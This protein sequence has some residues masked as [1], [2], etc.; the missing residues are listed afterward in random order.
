[1]K[2]KEVIQLIE[3]FAPLNLQESYDNA[4]LN[5]G[6]SENDVSGVLCT[7]DIT[8]KVIEEAIEL[9][10]NLIISHHPII[11][12]GIKSL[13]GRSENERIVIQAIQ[14]DIALYAAHTN[15]DNATGGVNHKIA[16]KL[17][18]SKLRVLE[19]IKNSLLKL[20][21]FVPE[22]HAEHVR[23]ALFQ[24]G[25]GTI[26]NYDSCSYNLNGTGTF[27]GGEE[28]E[29][30]VGE[31]GKLH[32][33]NEIRIETIVP[34]YLLKSVLKKL[35]ES[36]PYEEVAYDLYPLLNE[37]PL[38]GA[39]LIGELGTGITADNLLDQL[40]AAFHP[41]AIRY[42]GKTDQKIKKVAVCGGAGSFLIARAIQSKADAFV[43]GDLKYHQFFDAEDKI[44]L[45]DI[46]HYESE[47]F[48]KEIFYTLLTKKLSNFAVHLSKV[49]TNP[50]K[51]HV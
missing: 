47:Q 36:H 16:E 28:T 5:V 29:P 27:R 6:N 33:E 40:K 7:I 38:A 34:N 32:Y 12:T 41:P 45:C 49:V 3:D 13:T 42:A 11:F 50:I 39:G 15:I 51:Y 4:G 8:E 2:I 24:S 14:H 37:N 10:A 25:A 1:M 48:T 9:K 43:T 44:L 22:E 20:V 46:G 23:Q 17:G 31:K 19:P 21:T 35:F 18:L 30:F 26:G